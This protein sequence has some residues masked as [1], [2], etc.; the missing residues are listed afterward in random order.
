MNLLATS[1]IDV[2]HA[3]TGIPTIF[4]NPGPHQ[5]SS[6]LTHQ[7]SVTL[8][9]PP[10]LP[11]HASAGALFLRL[12][13]AA[14]LTSSSSS[15]AAS[16]RPFLFLRTSGAVCCRRSCFAPFSGSAPVSPRASRDGSREAERDG[17]RGSARDCSTDSERDGSREAQRDGSEGSERDCSTDS[18][19]V[20][21]RDSEPF[22]FPRP[23]PGS[24]KAFWDTICWR[25]AAASRAA[26]VEKNVEVRA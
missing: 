26:A 16:S 3:R 22:R 13:S 20:F 21:S 17:S 15:A 8:S 1:G 23:P 2:R 14:R 18:E 25:R 24:N 11:R 10:V 19:R 12:R 7:G 5:D 4:P 6:T 9:A